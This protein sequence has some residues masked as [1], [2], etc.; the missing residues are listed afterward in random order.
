MT[1]RFS[2]LVSSLGLFAINTTLLGATGTLFG[3]GSANLWNPVGWSL[4]ALG[5]V[6]SIFVHFKKKEAHKKKQ[7]AIEELS[8]HIKQR[9]EDKRNEVRSI[10]YDEVQNRIAK[11]EREYIKSIVELS[12]FLKFYVTK[13]EA[14]SNKINAGL[15]AAELKKYNVL[16]QLIFNGTDLDVANI[17]KTNQNVILQVKGQLPKNTTVCVEALSRLDGKYTIHI[18]NV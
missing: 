10:F 16:L 9:L 14:E 6:S 1:S 18:E 12:E 15:R 5:V 7:Q 11:I 17:F 13:L 3:F 2:G 4:G 8:S